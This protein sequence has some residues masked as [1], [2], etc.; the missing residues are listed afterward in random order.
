MAL[1]EAPGKKQKAGGG[2]R[3]RHRPGDHPVPGRGYRPAPRAA[4]QEAGLFYLLP[5]ANAF[6]AALISAPDQPGASRGG[7]WP[8]GPAAV[9]EP[10]GPGQPALSADAKSWQA[11]TRGEI[12]ALVLVENDPFWSFGDEE[13]LAWALE[14]LEL[15]VVL[16]Y[17]PSPVVKRAHVVL[18]TVTL[19]ERTAGVLR[20]PG[21]PGPNRA[22]GALRGDA[23]GPHQPRR[24][25]APDLSQPRPRERPPDPGR[26]FSRADPGPVWAS[27]PRPRWTCGPGWAGKTPF[28][29]RW[30][31]LAEH[32]EGV[33]LLPGAQPE[34]DFT[35]SPGPPGAWPP[36]SWNSCWWTG[37]SAPRNWRV[38]QPSCGGRKRR[39]CC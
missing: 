8:W 23:A 32:P 7:Q 28:S 9:G 18:P 4:G 36:I 24:P 15:L 12:K 1:A 2:L 30:R 13:R 34:G 33:R 37:P 39:R 27:G 38:T 25:S 6:G 26:D 16:D 20:Q 10:V 19:F 11:S 21:G 31:T 17:L 22:A 29:G 35:A 3:H 14:R 5:G